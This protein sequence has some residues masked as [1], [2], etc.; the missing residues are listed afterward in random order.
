M[1]NVTRIDA[2]D[3]VEVG[4]A[5]DLVLAADGSPM[6]GL[7][8]E[9]EIVN[10]TPALHSRYGDVRVYAECFVIS[11]EQHVL[12]VW[13][14]N[15]GGCPYQNVRAPRRCTKPRLKRGPASYVRKDFAIALGRALTL[16]ER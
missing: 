11:R 8:E 2:V 15:C 14:L 6:D 10:V 4:T 1:A 5:Y 3:E 7:M 16:R 9:I 12:K 13:I